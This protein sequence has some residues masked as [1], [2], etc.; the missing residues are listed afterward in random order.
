M[1]PFTIFCH[2]SDEN[3]SKFKCKVVTTKFCVN[4]TYVLL[5]KYNSFLWSDDK[6]LNCNRK[7]LN[8]GWKN[9]QW[10]A[11][12][13]I[14]NF[15][16]IL[17]TVL[18]HWGL[19]E[20]DAILQTTFSN[21]FSWMK[22]YEFRLRFHWNLF[23]GIQLT[24]F[25]HWFRWWLGADQATS[26]YLNQWWLFYWCIYAS[27]GLNELRF[28]IIVNMSFCSMFPKWVRMSG[29]QFW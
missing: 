3:S 9:C 28:L 12:Q 22:M 25:Q 21:A 14:S 19:D 13:I 27:L 29:S 16:Y 18:T 2:R 10:N 4:N 1:N 20:I 6:R 11:L 7:I 23:P 15:Q 24:I 8:C 17:L 5:F 26:H